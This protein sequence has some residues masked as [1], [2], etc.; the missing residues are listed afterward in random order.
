MV[1]GSKSQRSCGVACGERHLPAIFRL[2]Q[3][4]LNLKP[5]PERLH[6][7]G[8]HGR[9]R[10]DHYSATDG[11]ALATWLIAVTDR[12]NDA[13]TRHGHL[14][15]R[16]AAQRRQHEPGIAGRAN[17]AQ[18]AGDY[19]RKFRGRGG[20]PGMLAADGKGGSGEDAVHRPARRPRRPARRCRRLRREG[21]SLR[22]LASTS[23]IHSKKW[24]RSCTTPMRRP[25]KSNLPAC[26]KARARC[27][28]VR[29]QS[30]SGSG[31]RTLPCNQTLERRRIQQFDVATLH[32]HQPRVLQT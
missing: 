16:K 7:V 30:A 21:P 27:R 14:P 8:F 22:H 18:F 11:A 17:G 23:C 2:R 13:P 1:S 10:R 29:S 19:G 32:L 3:G 4:A 25:S 24:D 15:G 5:S 26:A 20:F 12:W 9:V 31:P 28:D 6:S